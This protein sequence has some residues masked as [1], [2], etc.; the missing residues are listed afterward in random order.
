M[1][2]ACSK[3]RDAFVRAQQ[4]LADAEFALWAAGQDLESAMWTSGAADVKLIGCVL[5][6]NFTDAVSIGRA[7]NCIIEQNM[8]DSAAQARLEAANARYKRAEQQRRRARRAFNDAQKALATCRQ[9]RQR[10]ARPPKAGGHW[11]GSILFIYREE[12]TGPFPLVQVRAHEYREEHLWEISGVPDDP[13]A[14]REHRYPAIWEARV[15]ARLV[16]DWDTG[17]IHGEGGQTGAATASSSI[18]ITLDEDGAY[19]ILGPALLQTRPNAV[20]SIFV[21]TS[22]DQTNEN[23]DTLD[24]TE[25]PIDRSGSVPPRSYV[26]AGKTGSRRTTPRMK[27]AAH[28]PNPR[29]FA[30][31]SWAF[32]REP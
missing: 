9:G 16:W 18:S 7:I 26:I 12:F 20:N 19:Q 17:D 6:F 23:R 24:L 25:E 10:A 28:P 2:P 22:P 5:G 21:V 13:E 29:A 11:R 31:W 14:E 32:W 27:L 4:D 3:E 1:A 30:T 15:A 8:V